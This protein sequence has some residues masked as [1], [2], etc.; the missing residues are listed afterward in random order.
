MSTA[1]VTGGGRGIGRGIALRLAKEGWKVAV[2]ARSTDEVAETARLS[3]GAILAV[4]ADVSREEDVRAMTAQTERDLGGIDLLVNNAGIG[5]PLAPFLE[6]SPDE[7]WKTLE[8]NLRGPYLCCRAVLPGMIA[9]GSG[10]IVNMASGAGT[11]PIPDMSAYVASKTALIR[12]S[13]QLAVEMKPHGITVFPIRPGVVR[14][15]M[16]E[17]A[18]GAVP[19]IQKILDEGQDVTPDVVAELVLFLASG[20]ADQLS[21]RLFSVNEDVDEIVRRAEEVESGNLYVLR[22]RRL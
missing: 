14:T 15:A 6:A 12:L 17:Q 11:F 5:G 18:R 10:R 3:G 19:L 4:T 9:Q 20:K 22:S 16:V 8:V 2:A 13:E 21:G 1:L 7:W